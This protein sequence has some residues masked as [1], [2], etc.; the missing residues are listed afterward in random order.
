MVALSLAVFFFGSALFGR[1]PLFL[2][3]LHYAG[4]YQFADD[5]LIPASQGFPQ[6]RLWSQAEQGEL[7]HSSNQRWAE[8]T[9]EFVEHPNC[10]MKPERGPCKGAVETFY[11]DDK[12]GACKSALWGGCQGVIPFGTLEDC[13]QACAPA[14]FLHEQT[15][16]LK[17]E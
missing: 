15:P 9:R 8:L 3:A 4:P 16:I 11:F 17:G 7:E 1:E 2:Q 12:T 10:R 6:A 14:R 5:I 13:E